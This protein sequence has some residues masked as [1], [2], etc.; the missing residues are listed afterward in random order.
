MSLQA[1][2]TRRE[3][4]QLFKTSALAAP[5]AWLAACS[6]ERTSRSAPA[7]PESD[8][9]VLDE[10]ERCAFQ[11]F[12]NEAGPATGQVKDRALANGND[13]RTVSSIAA[14]GFGLTALCIGD[15]RGYGSSASIKER[16]RVTLR[17]VASQ[18]PNQHGFFYH[19]VDMNSG[20]RVWNCELSSIDTALLLCGVLTARRHFADAEIQGLATTIYERVD[21]PWMLNGGPTLS[22]GWKPETGF[23]EARWNH[24]SE[25][26]MI[27]LLAIGSPTHPIPAQSWQAWSRPVITYQGIEYISGND[28]LFTHQYS[29]AWFDFRN[30]K[31]VFANYFQNSITATQAHR[32]F[33]ISLSGQFSDYSADLWGIT[34]SDSKNGYVAWGGPSAQGGVIGPVDGSIVPCA[35]AG[36]LPLD[37]S[38]AIH[39][40]RWIR[41]HYP[42]AWQRYGYV[43]AFDPLTGWYDTDVLGID[44]GISMLMAENYRT[45]LIWN[46]FMKNPEAQTAMQRAG[47]S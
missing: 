7:S 4:L 43:D 14:T 9:Q 30:K 1:S 16:V 2:L 6:S 21:W 34:S 22:M 8:E 15:A 35:T 37:F 45:Q 27:Y 23:L 18:L 13:T 32:L 28:P 44:L 25:L 38:D 31:D 42:A 39:V 17:Y 29:H 36:S 12:W 24:Y 11:F 26:M 46:T 41:G 5:L 40:L 3:L 47:F 33:C 20:V 19:F 10:I